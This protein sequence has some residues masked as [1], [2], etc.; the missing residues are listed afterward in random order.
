MRNASASPSTNTR[1]SAAARLERLPLSGYHKLIFTII[2]LAFFFDSVDLGTMTFVLGSIKKEFALT[3]AQAGLVASSSFFGMTLGAAVAGLLADRF[4]RRP[5]FQWSMVLWGV[6]SYLCSTAHDMNMLIVY[7]ILLG[8]GMGMEF[9][10]AQALLSEFVPAAKRGRLVALMDGFWPLGFITAG[11]VSYFVLPA[12]GWRTVFALLAIPAV[13]VLV[14]RRI[15]PESPRWL[16]H[17]GHAAEAD[18]VV[19][20]IEA[21]VMQSTGLVSLPAPARIVE[22]APTR[23]RSALREIWSTAY[24]RRTAMVWALW[25]FALLGFYGLT[26]W[27][28]A[29]LQ[30]AGFAV[31]QSVFYT[32]LISL[33]GVPGF[34]CAAWLV[35]VWGRKPT[36]VV[37]LLGGGVMA[38]AYGQTALHGA[39]I[40]LLIGTG[41]VMQ[42]FLFAMWAALYT[43]TPELYGTGA[44]ATGS[45]FASAIGRVGSLIGP[46]AVGVVL[47]M[48][49]Q[50]GV[51]MLGA[52]SFAVAA[53]AVW[54]LGVETKG[55]S[56]E[57]LTS[58]D[59]SGAA[60]PLAGSGVWEKRVN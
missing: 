48:F 44:R 41:L 5:V 39:S 11:I 23:G 26:S 4:G 43:Y 17:R 54:V 56:L 47:P 21:R 22:A 16:E 28:G 34:L 38:Y 3:N 46:C 10:I 8:F 33:G 19:S 55:L 35:E 59:D 1:A 29:L 57:A 2:A 40:P 45:G 27:L 14:V 60:L 6:A 49:G 52:L 15:V 20:M 13:F 51:F 24:R 36:C 37:S 25:F 53:L 50:G 42:F 12:L 30:Q 18:R 9:P 7:R 32:V 31:T 58:S